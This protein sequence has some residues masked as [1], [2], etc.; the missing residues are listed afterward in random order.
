MD[1]IL[2]DLKPMTKREALMLNPLQLAYIGDTVWDLL[3]RQSLLHT[4]HGVHAMHKM[5]SAQV[6][7]GAQAQTLSQ[8]TDI[9][10]ED[11][12]SLVRRG[13]NT[14]SKHPVPKHQDAA[15]YGMATGLE[16][17]IGFLYL[18]GDHDRIKALYHM[19]KEGHRDEKN[20]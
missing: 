7:A 16:A 8:L 17:L 15:D 18:T 3:V 14:R 1:E 20:A 11:E 12:L 6:N 9:L 19:A 10:F 13:R 4:G 2:M 5:A